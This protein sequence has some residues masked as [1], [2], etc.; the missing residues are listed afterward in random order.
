MAAHSEIECYYLSEK[1]ERDRVRKTVWDQI[2]SVDEKVESINEYLTTQL[3]ATAERNEEQDK[4]LEEL[5]GL[6]QENA[7]IQ[8]EAEKKIEALSIHLNNGWK[9]KFME[10]LTN[11]LFHMLEATG[12][13]VYKLRTQQEDLKAKQE[14]LKKMKIEKNKAVWLEVL[15]LVGTVVATVLGTGGIVMVL[16]RG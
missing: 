8:I 14:E 2:K 1:A 9:T 6:I 11:K 3:N 16:L 7:A 4:Q 5:K 13:Q 12:S 10:E 15:K